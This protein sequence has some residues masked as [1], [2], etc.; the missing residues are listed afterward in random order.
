MLALALIGVQYYFNK[1]MAQEAI[2]ESF[3][4]ASHKIVQYLKSQDTLSKEI[5]NQTEVHSM[6][7]LHA[8]TLFSEKL[9]QHFVHTMKRHNEM[10]AVYIGYENGDLFEVV[11]MKAGQRLYTHYK[12][13]TDTR[14]TVIWIHETSDGRVREF[15]FY[16][17]GL[18]RLSASKEPSNYKVTTRSWYQEA[19]L[20]SKAFRSDP[21]LFSN[22]QEKGIT[23]AKRIA[24]SKNVLAL[25]FTLDEIHNLVSS[26]KFSPSNNI[27][28]YGS[29]GECISST[30]SSSPNDLEKKIRNMVKKKQTEVIHEIDTGEGVNVAMVI[31]LTSEL[32]NETY[33]GITVS[34]KE[35]MQP[36]M[37]TLYYALAVA[38]MLLLLFIPLTLY[39]TDRIV[40]PVRALMRENEMIKQ[41]RFDSVK[42]IKS[43]ILEFIE[44]SHSQI[45]MSQ[46]IRDYQRQLETLLD[47]FIRLIAD[48]IDAKSTYT[49][50]HCKKVPVIATMLAD[51]AEASTE[52]MFESFHFRSEDERTA[53]ARAAWLHDCGKITTPEYVV[54]K[55]TKLETIYNRIHEIRTRFEVLWR[56]IEIEY[57][58]RL[59]EGEEKDILDAWK[60]KAQKILQEEFRFIAS[61]NIGDR[62]MDESDIQR[63]HQIAQRTWRRHFDDRLGLSDEEKKYY[64]APSCSLPANEKLL[65]DRPEHLIP[66]IGF[67]EVQYKEEGF[68]LEVP[69]WLYNRGELHN[70][71][72]PKG[73]LTP[74]ER[75]KINEH[76]IMT[77]KML[78]SLPFPDTM[79]EI[80]K[81]A[82]EH[83]ETMDGTGYPRKLKRSELSIPSRILAIADIFEALT[84]S[85]RPYKKAKT[86]SE[87]LKIMYMMKKESHIDPDL[88]DLFVRSR[89]YMEYAQ[90]YLSPE[91]ID[92]VD[93]ASLLH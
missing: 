68:K 24:E 69:Q 72:T 57:Y 26:L 85:D 46:S 84:A 71:S 65:S 32:G 93:E 63:L 14:W 9:F 3:H 18:K 22:L 33:V 88:F 67:D 36:Y 79:K 59:L 6:A 75:Y 27:F 16:D 42:P 55:A 13:P 50:S 11:N 91:Q 44:L 43:N 23:Y 29:N 51:A 38:F 8:P 81:F 15:I 49:G 76:V 37:Q 45:V 86:L 77:I 34:K 82:G 35:M 17:H 56:D 54:D 39:F 83:H 19:L 1:K 10:Y 7:G 62:Y 41:R 70:L 40:K 61:C 31:P 30:R 60:C 89:I 90:T 21:Y 25:D 64:N 58:Q 28:M 2:N 53:F 4:T 87:A 52:G 48:T 66:R 47:S 78:E 92:E 73:T 74:E 12:A 5:L 20:S 80:P